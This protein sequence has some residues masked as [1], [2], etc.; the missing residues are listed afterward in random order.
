MVQVQPEQAVPAVAPAPADLRRARISALVWL[1]IWVF[2][3]L[4]A[5]WT[6]ARAWPYVGHM[7]Q[8]LTVLAVPG[9]LFRVTDL[10]WMAKKQARLQGYQRKIARVVS[11]LGGMAGGAF[12]WGP[13]DQLSMA[14]FEREFAPLVADIHAR[15]AAPC[16]PAASYA[17]GPSLAAYA[18]ET[19]SPRTA[20]LHADAQRFVLT[21]PG[22]S[23]DIDG[24]S[25]IYTSRTRVWSKRHNDHLAATG[26]LAMLTQGLQECRIDLRK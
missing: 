14:R 23:M 1:G 19:Q 11:I 8:W 2:L 5:S 18:E 17:I 9:I 22:R 4:W 12:L 16:P 25:L 26:E 24:S 13:L 20:T 7:A 3:T 10:L 21:V 6:L 15:A